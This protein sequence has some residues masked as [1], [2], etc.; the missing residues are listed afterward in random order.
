MYNA[1]DGGAVIA[2]VVGGSRG[3]TGY[4]LSRFKVA[5]IGLLVNDQISTLVLGDDKFYY[6]IS[7]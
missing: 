2:T 7:A 6:R 4:R 5:L 1:P 3:Y